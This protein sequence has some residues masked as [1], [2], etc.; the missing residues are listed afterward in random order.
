MVKTFSFFITILF[1]FIISVSTQVQAQWVE[2]T[3]PTANALFTVSV[4]D[5]SVAWIGGTNGTV[6]RTTDGGAN[7]TNV[8]GGAIG[9]GPVYNIF[10]L[11]AQTA[12]CTASPS[13]TFIYR[14]TNG[15]STW[16]QVFTNSSGFMD[17]I[18]MFDANNGFAYGDPVG[19]NWELYNTSDGGATW[20]AAPNLAQA[21]S[22]AGWNNAMYVT[23]TRIW[24]G[25]NNSRIYYS[26]DSGNSW[27]PQTTTQINS[28]SVWF[29]NAA[30]GMMGGESA[31]NQTTNGG[32]TWTL[33]S[34][35][36]NTGI[37]GALTSFNGQWWAARQLNTIFYSTDNGASWTTQYTA[38]TSGVYYAMS[39]S[40]NGNLII[41][42]RSDGGISA[43]TIIIPV[44]LTSFTASTNNLGQVVLNWQTATE[45]NN[46]MFE[47][48]RKTDNSDYSI[49]GFVN[50]AGTTTNPQSYT[51]VDKNVNRGNYTYRLKQID[52]DGHFQYSNAVEVV[53]AGPMTFD[54]AQNY[55]NPFNPST[56]INF[57]VPDQGNVKLSVYNAIGQEVA[58][59]LNGAV[60]PGQHEVTFNANSLP[61]G[62]YFYKLQS[63]SSVMIKKMLLL[64]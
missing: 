17:A 38:P 18:W 33:L 20:T 55:P 45:T 14:T 3:S 6:L 56:K 47:I 60:T 30:N 31:L 24:F 22:E 42:A 16:T 35:L 64:K 32:N 4:V 11:D 37:I 54:L 46:R 2:Q 28:Y 5:N 62:A 53:V 27:T 12:I 50:G 43:Y 48:E 10:A 57:S 19:G 44:E 40:R 25:T 63:G 36:P 58:V 13:G 41:A 61:S 26:T 52:F 34:T 1:A 59:L 21:G 15:G 23:G 51:F 29:D 39:R 9:T 7:W 49:V 8:G